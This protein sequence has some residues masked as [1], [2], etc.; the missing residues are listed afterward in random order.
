MLFRS[1]VSAALDE[2]NVYADKTIY[3]F[4]Q[5]TANIGKFTAAGVG[6]SDSVSAIKG[7]SNLAAMFGVDAA[8]A[9]NA[10]YQ[11]SQAISS[12]VVRL[13]DWNSVQNAGMGGEAFQEALIRTARLH[14]EAVDEAIEKNGS[15]RESLKENW[16]TAEVMLSTLSQFTGDLTDYEIGRASC[17][18]RV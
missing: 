2:L 10:M 16:L 1:T 4:G 17:R 14:G 6:L 7:L 5:M 12:G 18:E 8:S 15:F 13:Q 11:L 3:N 9:S